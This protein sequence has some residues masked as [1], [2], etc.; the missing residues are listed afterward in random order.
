MNGRVEV[1][2]GTPGRKARDRDRELNCW[3]D[4]GETFL[5]SI[6]AGSMSPS[7]ARVIHPRILL[8]SFIWKLAESMYCGYRD[9]VKRVSACSQCTRFHAST[10]FQEH[11][12]KLSSTTKW[13][14][15]S[16]PVHTIRET[17]THDLKRF[18]CGRGNSLEGRRLYSVT[19][20]GSGI[21]Q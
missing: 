9:S 2:Y 1:A 16:M 19:W 13:T 12:Q 21:C 11:E 17:D 20:S 8:C 15:Y 10:G 4:C 5:N 7:R 18:S 3:Q 6:T 14:V